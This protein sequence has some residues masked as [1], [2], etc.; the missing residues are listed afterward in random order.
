MGAEHANHVAFV[1]A[2]IGAVNSLKTNLS[3]PYHQDTKFSV[4]IQNVP[5]EID[6]FLEKLRAALLNEGYQ[7]EPAKVISTRISKIIQV[8]G[9]DLTSYDPLGGK[10]YTDENGNPT[11]DIS[12]EP[13]SDMHMWNPFSVN[14]PMQSMP[15]NR[16]T[17]IIGVE[18]NVKQI[19]NVTEELFDYNIIGGFIYESK[20]L[21]KL[22]FFTVLVC[23]GLSI[24]FVINTHLGFWKEAGIVLGSIVI[25]F[26]MFSFYVTY[27]VRKHRDQLQRIIS[28]FVNSFVH[29][30]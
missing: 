20:L 28:K 5:I 13:P 6:N 4:G 2:S 24:Y 3:T 23:A 1:K 16:F 9:V 27:K 12:W 8:A 29:N 15:I 30:Q 19:L 7:S 25:P 18:F 10:M 17:A 21:R 22:D 11:I 14:F 26:L